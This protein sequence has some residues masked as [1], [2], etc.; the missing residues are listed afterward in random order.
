PV[1]LRESRGSSF[2]QYKFVDQSEF[3]ND[4]RSTENTTAF[5]ARRR[6]RRWRKNRL[7][8]PISAPGRPT[9]RCMGRHY[10]F[11]AQ[12]SVVYLSRPRNPPYNTNTTFPPLYA[13]PAPRYSLN[14]LPSKV[15]SKPFYTPHFS[16]H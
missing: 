1:N 8:H 12:R 4:V 13:V 5:C 9:G 7:P 10:Y 15:P 6:F 16:V 3:L 11:P 2:G 14:S